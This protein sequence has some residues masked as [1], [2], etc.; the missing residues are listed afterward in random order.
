[1]NEAAEHVYSAP[2][3]S[4]YVAGALIG[5][6]AVATL[7]VAQHKVSA[8]S[9]YAHV[10]G[11]LGRLI[12]PRHVAALPFFRE[13][14]PTLSW[15]LVFIAGAVA[16]SFIAAS[17][18]GELKGSYLPDLWVARFGA[19][20]YGLRTAAALAGGVL[21]AFGARM[22]GGCTSGHGITGTM[23]L[24]VSSWISV[25]CFFLGGALVASPLYR[26]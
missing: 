17:T 19:D 1:V 15:S 8:S 25:L 26:I 10:A 9:A 18:G 16:G 7:A 14:R 11:L 4:P 23:Q 6:L 12:A 22:A 5:L 20:S 3:W 24:A 2:A 13:N 21:M